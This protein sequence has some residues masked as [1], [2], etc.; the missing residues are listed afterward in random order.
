[1]FLIAASGRRHLCAEEPYCFSTPS[2]SSP[3]AITWLQSVFPV[4]LPSQ[5]PTLHSS[6][7]R[8]FHVQCCVF[9][10]HLAFGRGT[11]P[12]KNAFLLLLHLTVLTLNPVRSPSVPSTPWL[13]SEALVPFLHSLWLMLLLCSFHLT[14]SLHMLVCGSHR[15]LLKGQ[16]HFPITLELPTQ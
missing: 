16:H 9:S 13:P 5:T 10:H 4:L 3:Y 11:A 7:F 1:M 14:P 2:G 8:L 12:A 15:K 6:N